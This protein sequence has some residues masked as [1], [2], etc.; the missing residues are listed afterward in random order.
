M[1][2]LKHQFAFIGWLIWLWETQKH[3][4][5]NKKPECAQDVFGHSATLTSG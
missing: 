4:K 3:A 1:S 2:L 5:H